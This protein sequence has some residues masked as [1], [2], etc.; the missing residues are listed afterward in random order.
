MSETRPA[1]GGPRFTAALYCAVLLAA[2]LLSNELLRLALPDR[3]RIALVLAQVLGL[4]LPALA[5]SRGFAALGRPPATSRR[6]A[7]RP[8]ALALALPGLMIGGLLL[9]VAVHHAWLRALASTGWEWIAKW[10]AL[11]TESYE[12]LL[13]A[14]G[15]LELA[16]VLI[17]VSLVPAACEEVAFRR[18]LQGLLATRAGGVTAVLGSAAVFSAFHLD[19]FGLPARFLLGISLGTLYHRTGALWTAALLHALHNLAI[20]SGMQLAEAAGTGAA[21]SS[22]EGL[23]QVPPAQVAGLA[24]A[25][26]LLWL[27]SLAL[28]APPSMRESE[29]PG[30]TLD[31]EAGAA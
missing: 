8:F 2:W 26:L 1:D 25:G 12:I 28:L 11:V 14:D 24:A 10:D 3:P 18:G 21:L 20:V 17:M 31:D 27:A 30:G 16:G 22:L 7:P 19:P 29:E 5:L 4:L 6:P 13:K 9:G 15:R 23:E